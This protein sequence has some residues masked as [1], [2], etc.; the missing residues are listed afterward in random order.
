MATKRRSA[1]R[2]A[3]LALQR[4]SEWRGQEFARERVF[5]IGDTPADVACARAIGA[6]AIAITTG[7]SPREDLLAAA[8]DQLVDSFHELG[9]LLD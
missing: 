4:A 6:R 1:I 9:T 7:Y 8:P 2:L 3:Q 5:V